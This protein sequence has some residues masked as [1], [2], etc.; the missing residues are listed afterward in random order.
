MR[1]ILVRHGRTVENE[2]HI[3]QGYL[4]G[5]LS[6]EGKMQAK[7]VA[8]RLSREDIDFCFS[9]DLKR[10]AD[11]AKEIARQ[12]PDGLKIIFMKQLRE[13]NVGELQGKT[14]EDVGWD[15]V[16]KKLNR[17]WKPKGGESFKEFEGRLGSFW[18]KLHKTKRYKDKTIL[19]VSHGGALKIL[20]S[21]IMNMDTFDAF[22]FKTSNA[23]ITTIEVNNGKRTLIN[24]NC[25]E[26][27]CYPK[28]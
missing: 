15:A 3:H 23:A 14:R 10:A 28:R 4:P 7:Q 2:L 22:K 21:K 18:Q 20:L 8:K 5:H 1:L 11:T 16:K 17:G 9:S 13:L 27:L 25:T 19:I 12:H 6:K 24:Y 26:H